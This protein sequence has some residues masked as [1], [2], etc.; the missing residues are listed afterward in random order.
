MIKKFGTEKGVIESIT[1]AI[2]DQTNAL[3]E[4]S[5]RSYYQ[6]KNKFNMK[7]LE[8][9]N[10][11]IGYRLVIQMMI[12]SNPIWIRWSTQCDIVFMS[13]KPQAMKY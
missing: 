12:V 10:S 1:S 2:N 9:I 4:L 11:L 6:A 7:K 13:W 8:V 5:R 3:D